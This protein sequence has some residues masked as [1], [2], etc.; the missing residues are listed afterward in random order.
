[1]DD[2]Q[3]L[4]IYILGAFILGAGLGYYFTQALFG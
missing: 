1:M 2:L 3:G 4:I